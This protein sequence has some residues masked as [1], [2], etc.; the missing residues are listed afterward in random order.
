MET[1]KKLNH[2]EIGIDLKDGLSANYENEELVIKNE[3]S[4][5]SKK[6][7]FKDVK[8]LTQDKKILIKTEKFSK[9]N[10]KIIFTYKAHV[11]NMIKGLTEGFI[12]ELR[13]VYSKFPIMVE[14]KNNEFIVKNLLGEKKN[15]SLK[16][17]EDV[18]VDIKGK[19]IFVS[20]IDKERVGQMSAN[21]EQLCR[22]THFDRRVIQDGIYITKKPHR[23]YTE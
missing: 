5:I 16:I 17:Y 18:K 13:V 8:I 21:I 15:R 9:R 4:E 14:A 22:I 3:K 11:N 23:V 6:L 1:K 20:G 2:Y 10:K 19:D 7:F 12:Y